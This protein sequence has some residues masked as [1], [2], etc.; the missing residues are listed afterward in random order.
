M[1]LT[2]KGR[3]GVRIV[4]DIAQHQDQGPVSML[5]ISQRQ[6]VSMKYLERIVGDLRRAGFVNSMRGRNGGHQ[7]ARAPENITVGDIVRAME[8]G[9]VTLACGMDRLQCDRSAECLMRSIWI[10]ADQAVFE[11]LDSVSI[12]DVLRDD[13]GCLYRSEADLPL[14]E[15]E[16]AAPAGLVRSLGLDVAPSQEECGCVS[17]AEHHSP[18]PVSGLVRKLAS[19]RLVRRRVALPQPEKARERKIMVV[20]DDPEIV[21]YLT[22]LLRDDGYEVCS[23]ADGSMAMA[24][25]RRELPDLI[26]LDLEMP[27]AWG[28]RF[29]ARFTQID[30]YRNIPVVVISGLADA[31]K[32]IP[33]ALATFPKPFDPDAVLRVVRKAIG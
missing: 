14:S 8:N 3:Y 25:L 1:R 33:Q 23:A 31:E 29:Y 13:I 20:D 2:T 21:E 4:L 26:T 17:V 7:L 5:D 10:D 16:P 6:G 27:G 30:E 12:L 18:A 19:R 15:N 11:R 24:V 32:A 22:D 9:G 28:P